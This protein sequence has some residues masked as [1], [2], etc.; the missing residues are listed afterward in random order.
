VSQI[1]LPTLLHC[2]HIIVMLN[3]VT[4][5]GGNEVSSS[6]RTDCELLITSH[7]VITVA[8]GS[9]KGVGALFN[10]HGDDGHSRKRSIGP[11]CVLD[12]CIASIIFWTELCFCAH[13]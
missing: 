9:T 5:Y 10:L 7:S 12:C 1:G 4:A 11:S 13:L 8:F 3:Y 2:F 6:Q